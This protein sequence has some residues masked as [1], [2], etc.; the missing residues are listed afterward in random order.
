MNKNGKSKETVKQIEDRLTYL[1]EYD[2]NNPEIYE[3]LKRLAKIYIFQNKYI[4]GYSDIDAVCHDVAADTY[5]RLLKGRTKIT[6]WIYYI[7][8]SIKLS[9]V[10]NQRKIEHEIIDTHG[11][12]ELRKSVINM[13][14]GS[15]NSFSSDFDAVNKSAFLVNI[16]ILIRRVMSHTKFKKDS[17]EWLTL[18]TNLCMSLYYNKLTYFR[19]S[20]GLK[21][22]VRLLLNQFR[23]EFIN[24]DFMQK[25]YDTDDELPTLI[26]YDEQSFKDNSNRKDI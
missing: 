8:R 7:G 1:S 4:Y 26:F 2:I 15:S 16:D 12:P 10:Q 5:M 18:Y 13:C 3:L 22:Y 11:N 24:S 14:A 25:D 21:P 20:K 17:K 19:I 23:M 9:Y 6:K